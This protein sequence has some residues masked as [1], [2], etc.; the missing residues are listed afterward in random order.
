MFGYLRTEVGDAV[1]A[2]TLRQ[3]CDG[4]VA[5]LAWL[6]GH[7]VPF[8]GSLCPDKTSYPTNRHYL[9]YSG[10]ELSEAG[11]APPA[12]RG[13]RTKGRGTSGGLLYARLAAAVRAAGVRVLTQTTAGELV[14]AP[15]GRVTGVECLTLRGAPG[16]VRLAHRVLHR[17]S[18]NPYLYVPKA[19][20]IL[21]RPVAW[22]ERRYGRAVRIGA[23]RGVVV[24]AGGFGA[25]RPMMRLH[26]PA[27]AAGCRWPPRDDGSGIRPGTGAAAGPR[28]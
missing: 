7:G 12:P 23:A 14:T 11:G 6:E 2:A 18:V 17:W 21:H 25:N 15:G 28:S 10:S 8:E 24:A 20:R 27:A 1:P 16:W 4:S 13:H 22:L 26:A 9:Y 19:G 3:F 5:M